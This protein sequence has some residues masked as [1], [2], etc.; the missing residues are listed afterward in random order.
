M[1]NKAPISA[2]R[3]PRVEGS[4][5]EKTP[6]VPSKKSKAAVGGMAASQMKRPKML[7]SP[8]KLDVRK[9]NPSSATKR[10]RHSLHDEDGPPRKKTLKLTIKRRSVSPSPDPNP[11]SCVEN[12]VDE[13]AEVRIPR[14]SSL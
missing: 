9:S 5:L 8:K 14:E 3:T 13:S 2:Q 11:S 10:L 4:V 12:M 6:R 1:P 7:S